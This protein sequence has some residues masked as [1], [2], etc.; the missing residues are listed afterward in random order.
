MENPM[1][2]LLWIVVAIVVIAAIFLVARQVVANGRRRALRTRFGPEYDRTVHKHGDDRDAAETELAEIARERSATP[3]RR[4]TDAERD[5]FA[6]RWTAVQTDF[7]EQPVEATQSA[8]ALVTDVLRT[9]GYPADEP[10]ARV[11][12][13]VADHPDLAEDYRTATAA[14]G[15]G[16][17][18]L[19]GSATPL[20]PE[21]TED[22]R[23]SLIAYRK[24]FDALVGDAVTTRAETAPANAAAADTAATEKTAASDDSAVV[25]R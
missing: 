5:A 17:D 15:R 13:V 20:A 22:L 7:V 6:E 8:D 18:A 25:S 24:V 9:R 2:A 10:D 21:A 3:V 23:T 11:R 19:N 14:T 1:S 12:S 16:V 4:L